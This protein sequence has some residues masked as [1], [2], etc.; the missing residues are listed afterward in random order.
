MAS[1]IPTLGPMYE[2]IRGK[3]SWSSHGRYEELIRVQ[4]AFLATAPR[5]PNIRGHKDIVV[6]AIVACRC[7]PTLG[8]MYE[9]IRGKRSWSSHGRYESSKLRSDTFLATAPRSPNIRGHKDIVVV[10]IVACRFLYGS[11][12]VCTR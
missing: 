3:R 1:C 5:S 6:V 2:M 11:I 8:P 10:A 4:D 12:R 7:I 9:M